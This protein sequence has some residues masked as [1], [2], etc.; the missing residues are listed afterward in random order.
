MLF[1][2]FLH[3]DVGSAKDN[4]LS[5]KAFFS[6]PHKCL[7]S[8]AGMLH[9]R[10]FL[11][12]CHII[13]KVCKDEQPQ[14]HLIPSCWWGMWL[15]CSSLTTL[16]CFSWCARCHPHRGPRLLLGIS[17]PGTGRAP[18]QRQW[19]LCPDGEEGKRISFHQEAF[20]LFY[21]IFNKET[22]YAASMPKTNDISSLIPKGISHS[23]SKALEVK[24]RILF[25]G[26][27]MWLAA[28]SLEKIFIW[29]VNSM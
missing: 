26:L 22:A 3:Q 7:L 29:K 18:Q 6:F 20:G 9:T 21:Y 13:K 12:P 25:W 11:V 14:S 1:L 19:R 27:C 2:V 5:W 17:H 28:K 4:T 16:L 8:I 15:C 24:R 23:F 10:Y